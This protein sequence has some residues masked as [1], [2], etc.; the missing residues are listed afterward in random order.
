MKKNILVVEDEKNLGETLNE[1]L[2]S[3]GFACQLAKNVKEAR[4]IF[5]RTDLSF[6]IVL[7]DIGLPD[8]NGIE[9]AAEFRAHSKNFV[10]FFLSALNDPDT[11]LKGL[12]IGAHD[13]IT[14]PFNLK[15]LLLRMERTFATQRELTNVT[16]PIQW[17][18]LKIW[19][20]RFEVE[21]GNG[22]IMNLSQK[23]CS[24][25]RFLVDSQNLALTREQIIEEVWGE[26][27]FPSNRTVDNYIVKLR[28]WLESD[29]NSGVEISSV[30]GIGY[31]LQ[32]RAKD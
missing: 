29:P 13:Y 18:K 7:M 10:L 23:E 31:K 20:N 24:I 12:E 16:D 21:D 1:Y 4:E 19:F 6:Q 17:G 8:G 5:Y 15:E 14:K 32:I 9:L 11:R 30:R 27:M 28:K 22:Q 3:K 2:Q 25:L 26:G